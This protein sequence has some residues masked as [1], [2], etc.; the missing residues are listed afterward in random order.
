MTTLQIG[1][2]TLI[3]GDAYKIVPTIGHVD[4][5]VTDPQ[6]EFSASG[7]G[8][9]RKARRKHMA[10]IEK[11]GLNKGF[12][13]RIIDPELYRSVVIFCHENQLIDI[14]F[15]LRQGYARTALCGWRKTNPVPMANKHYIAELEPYLHAWN[16]DGHPVGEIQERKRIFDYKNGGQSEFDHPTVKP[17]P[18]MEKIMKNVNGDSI[19]DPF[20][21]SGTTGVAALKAGK[22]F[23]GIEQDPSYFNIMVSRILATV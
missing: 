22:R 9:F 7:G 18:L 13:V 17:L 1:N 6:Y 16:K 19:I 2:A 4:A 5:M 11:A 3:L 20:A 12:D 14:W 15:Y 10:A 23:I 21:G 8:K